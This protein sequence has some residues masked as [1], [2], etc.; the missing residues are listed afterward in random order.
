MGE[1]DIRDVTI[2]I[3]VIYLYTVVWRIAWRQGYKEGECE[4]YWEHVIA[5]NWQ[6]YEEDEK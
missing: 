2:A 1:I 5:T 3:L 6:R 4:G